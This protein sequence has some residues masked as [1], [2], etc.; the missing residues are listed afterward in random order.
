M[1]T[2]SAGHRPAALSFTADAACILLFCA[3]GRRNHAEAMTLAGLG[4]T[5]WPFLVGMTAAWLIIRGWRRPT[6]V[7]PTGLAVWL[8]T[9]AV[10]MGLRAVNG[11]GT[12]PSFVLVATGVTGALLLSW[13]AGFTAY[14]ARRNGPRAV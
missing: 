2:T 7:R 14:T 13:R 5:S 4:R 8:G 6:A 9:I 11:A 10:G 12:A 1:T 3:L